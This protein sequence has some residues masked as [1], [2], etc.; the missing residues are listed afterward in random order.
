MQ[1]LTC[2]DLNIPICFIVGMSWGKKAKA[3]ARGNGKVTCKGCEPAEISVQI[4]IDP[5]LCDVYGLDIRK[6]IE[7]YSD[8]S[9]KK[10]SPSS[11]I[12]LGG[13]PI[14]PELEF[15]VT[16]VNKTEETDIAVKIPRLL[17]ADI[18][19]SGVKTVK[20]VSR[21]R[22]LD[23]STLGVS[24]PRVFIEV[25]GESLEIKEKFSIL[26]LVTTPSTANIDI[27]I[28][29]DTAIADQKSFIDS[30]MEKTAKVK[31][32]LPS[33]T[34]T[35][36]V[37]NSSLIDN[38]LSID[39]T[40]YPNEMS[41]PVQKTYMKKPLS[42]ILKDICRIGKIDCD[43]SNISG[44]VDYYKLDSSPIESL[45]F[46]QR[47]AGFLISKLG[48]KL[49]FHYLPEKFTAQNAI[50]CYIDDSVQ[51]E[52][53]RSVYWHDGINSSTASCDYEGDGVDIPSIFRSSDCK[54]YAEN[55]LKYINYM[56]NDL[57]LR[58]EADGRIVNHSSL[59]LK[60]NNVNLDVLVEY[61]EI[62]WVGEEMTIEAHYL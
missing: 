62:D 12:L 60:K 49:S 25:D 8:L 31:I 32:E 7:I 27:E 26:N 24:V 2:G 16:N 46:L 18:I 56:R 54:R 9:A 35:Y 1:Y 34:A 52:L 21:Q 23:F 38:T 61:F 28:G 40:I 45:R 5:S 43:S 11:P 55:V 59:A 17:T 58:A 29:D 36:F 39:C 37:I 6:S 44:D 53:A 33:G 3:N 20:E 48:N 47:S 50:E 4:A 19:F 57:T 41:I 15:A 14:M 22:A 42:Y 51:N 13:Y 10:D 30:V